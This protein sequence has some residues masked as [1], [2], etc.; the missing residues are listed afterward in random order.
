[1]YAYQEAYMLPQQNKALMI[2]SPVTTSED[3]NQQCV[4][5]LLNPSSCMQTKQHC[6]Q[7]PQPNRHLGLLTSSPS[8][9]RES[10]PPAL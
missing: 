3:K 7:K 2:L 6:C 9:P 1:M 8:F 5:V 10:R 4:L